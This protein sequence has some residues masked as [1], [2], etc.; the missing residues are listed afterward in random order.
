MAA[1]RGKI[2]H[3]YLA[4]VRFRGDLTE[5]REKL[6]QKTASVHVSFMEKGFYAAIRLISRVSILGRGSGAVQ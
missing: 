5:K 3:G 2:Q 1:V 4:V 6:T